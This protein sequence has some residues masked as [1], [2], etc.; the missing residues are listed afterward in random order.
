VTYYAE[1]SARDP[2]WREQQVREAK[3]REAAARELDPDAEPSCG[4]TVA[5]TFQ[6]SAFVL[7]G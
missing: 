2:A 4:R 1:R 7:R 5:G 6:H 3:E